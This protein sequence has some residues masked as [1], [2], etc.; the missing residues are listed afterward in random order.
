MESVKA[1]KWRYD[2]GPWLILSTLAER[3][4]H[5]SLSA[6]FPRREKLIS[7]IPG[8]FWWFL[9]A[10]I[11]FYPFTKSRYKSLEIVEN[12]EKWLEIESKH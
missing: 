10:E 12:D 4:F 6:E 9:T 1:S 8:D 7:L 2:N 3:D 5:E 11:S